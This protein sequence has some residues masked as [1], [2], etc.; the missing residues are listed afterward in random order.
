M[1]VFPISCCVLDLCRILFRK[2]NLTFHVFSNTSMD[3]WLSTVCLQS[4]T[5]KQQLCLC[6]NSKQ[7]KLRNSTFIG[8]KFINNTSLFCLILF[9]RRCSLLS[10]LVWSELIFVLMPVHKKLIYKFVCLNT[11]SR[12]FCF[13]FYFMT[14]SI[15][16]GC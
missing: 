14:S 15:L 16:E 2:R 11:N 8:N 7:S 13:R 4:R 6:C 9:F 12:Y 10:C 3:L 5:C 1:H